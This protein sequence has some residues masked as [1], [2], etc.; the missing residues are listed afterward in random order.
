MPSAV[1]YTSPALLVLLILVLQSGSA[2]DSLACKSKTAAQILDSS[3]TMI[4]AGAFASALQCL[5]RAIR[6]K[7]PDTV[8]FEAMSLQCE[9]EMGMGDSS[10]ALDSCMRAWEKQPDDSLTNLRL[11]NLLSGAGNHSGSVHFFEIAIQGRP[12]SPIPRNNLALALQVLGRK[13]DAIKVFEDA[14]LDTDAAAHGR[15][16][17]LTNLAVALPDDAIERKMDLLEEAY[18]LDFMD[19]TA[20]NLANNMC[21]DRSSDKDKC[22]GCRVLLEHHMSKFA[23]RGAFH[24]GIYRALAV[25]LNKLG[26]GQEATRVLKQ[27]G[28]LRGEAT[29]SA[30]LHGSLDQVFETA[31]GSLADLAMGMLTF[32]ASLAKQSLFEKDPKKFIFHSIRACFAG[33]RISPDSATLRLRFDCAQRLFHAAAYHSAE[34]MYTIALLRRYGKDGQTLQQLNTHFAAEAYNGIGASIEMQHERLD[35]AALAYSQAV[36]LV[37]EYHTAFF[38]YAHIKAT[39]HLIVLLQCSSPHVVTG[40]PV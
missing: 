32:G 14:I 1:F 23:K 4:A 17:V 21:N 10:A 25:C 12:D 35:V 5:P 29:V 40:T 15:S 2:A 38:S 30:A 3:R 7:M 31:S 6:P 20:V 36:K 22:E 11:G 37:P 13:D 8:F 26:M 18:A 24:E 34:R 19:E 16:M 33:L 39:P 27:S 9:A 28:S